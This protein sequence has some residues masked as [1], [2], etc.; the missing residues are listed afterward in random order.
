[1]ERKE[2]LRLKNMLRRLAKRLLIASLLVNLTDMAENQY[3]Q[4]VFDIGNTAEKNAFGGGVASPFEEYIMDVEGWH[5]EGI[6]SQEGG[7]K[8]A[9]WGHKMRPGD[10]FTGYTKGSDEAMNVLRQDLSEYT[11]QARQSTINKYGANSWENLPQDRKEMLIDYVYNTGRTPWML[12][13]DFKGP[14][15]RF[16]DAIM[17]KGDLDAME[18]NPNTGQEEWIGTRRFTDAEGNIQTLGRNKQ[19]RDYFGI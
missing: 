4:P 6:P 7:A 14:L 2:K 1:M 8:T 5:G 18:M 3:N 15:S 19:F 12:E 10:D 13:P 16:G 11:N 9:L 17:G